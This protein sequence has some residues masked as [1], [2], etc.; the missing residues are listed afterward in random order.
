MVSFSKIVINFAEEIIVWVKLLPLDH[1]FWILETLSY[2]KGIS[3]RPTCTDAITTKR[4]KW[5][6]CQKLLIHLY[7]LSRKGVI[8]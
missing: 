1:M 3:E 5:F 6:E 4:A 2:I 7:L 8:Q